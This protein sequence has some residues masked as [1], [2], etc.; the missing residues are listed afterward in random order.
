MPVLSSAGA[1]TASSSS[2]PP[3]SYINYVTKSITKVERR[4]K[5]LS[6]PLEHIRATYE[7][8]VEESQR[9]EQELEQI[10]AMRGG[11]QNKTLVNLGN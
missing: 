6:Y 9:S 5:V 4:I 10:L 3:D 2:K 1:A 11:A 7:Q 8:F